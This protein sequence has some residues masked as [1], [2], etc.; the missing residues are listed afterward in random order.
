MTHC[1]DCGEETKRRFRCP[2][3]KMLI[4]GWCWNHVH[5]FSKNEADAVER[6]KPHRVSQRAKRGEQ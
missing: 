4:C 1:E 5:S 3:C 6:H 2:R